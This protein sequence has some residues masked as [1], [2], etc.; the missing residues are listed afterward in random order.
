MRGSIFAL[1][2]FAAAGGACSSAGETADLA[3]ANPECAFASRLPTQSTSEEA[4]AMSK[5]GIDEIVASA[6]KSIRKDLEVFLEVTRDL[7]LKSREIAELPKDERE[8][9]SDDLLKLMS[10]RGYFKATEDVDNFVTD[11]C[12]GSDGLVPAR[13]SP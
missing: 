3:T 1:I 10:G 13:A 12:P 9:A 7:K 4:E 11:N 5:Q 8:D 6:P 2:M